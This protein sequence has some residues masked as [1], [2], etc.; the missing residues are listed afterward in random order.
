MSIAEVLW[1][2]WKYYGFF[3]MHEVWQNIRE[4]TQFEY[5]LTH[6]RWRSVYLWLVR[7]AIQWCERFL[8]APYHPHICEAVRVRRRRVWEEVFLEGLYD[9]AQTW[10]AREYYIQVPMRTIWIK[11]SKFHHLEI[12]TRAYTSER[13]LACTESTKNFVQKSHIKTHYDAKHK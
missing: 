8:K 12:Y 7:E 3:W 10:S 6:A 2:S 9:K 13:P 5:T 4:S 11:C 1:D